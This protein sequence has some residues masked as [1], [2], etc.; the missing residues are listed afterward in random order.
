MPSS[1]RSTPNAPSSCP[2]GWANTYTHTHT[3]THT[4]ALVLVF[5]CVGGGRCVCGC[6]RARVYRL[7]RMLPRACVSVCVC[8]CVCACVCVCVCVCA[9]VCVC[10]KR[11]L[12]SASRFLC[13]LARVLQCVAVCVSVLQCV[14]VWVPMGVRAFGTK[15]ASKELHDMGGLTGGPKRGMKSLG[16]L[17]LAKG[18]GLL[19][20]AIVFA[21]MQPGVRFIFSVYIVN[22]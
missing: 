19:M 15:S 4:R 12:T 17:M 20:L 10:S 18:R 3:H 2:R 13:T 14:A 5:V 21:A 7:V 6:T 9:C 1:D 11:H 22:L 16:W 8:V